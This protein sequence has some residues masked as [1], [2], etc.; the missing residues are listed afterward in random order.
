MTDNV[1][2]I[3]DAQDNRIKELP[4]GNNLDLTGSGIVNAASL[5]VSGSLTVNSITINS[6]SL[7]TVAFS[8]NYEDLDNT[9]TGFTGDYNDLTNKPT[10]PGI[11]K[12]LSDVSGDDPVGGDA[13][14]YDALEG[15]YRP[16]SIINQTDLDA[17][18][19]GAL[20]NVIIVGNVT[21]RFLKFSA[22]AWRPSKVQYAEVQN[23]PTNVS[24]F[25]NDAGYITSADIQEI[26]GDFE[27]SVFADDST[28]LVDGVAGK[29]VGNVDTSLIENT[30]GNLNINA[31]NYVVIDSTDNG[32]IEIGRASGVGDVIIGNSANGTDLLIDTSVSVSGNIVPDEADTYDLGS[33]DKPFRSLYLS[34]NT[35]IVGGYSLGIDNGNLKLTPPGENPGAE[36][37]EVDEVVS[38]ALVV[39]DNLFLDNNADMVL[40]SHVRFE[41][42]QQFG[43][44]VSTLGTTL[45]NS[46]IGFTEFGS[47]VISTS[48]APA[49]SIGQPGTPV[50]A[51][52]FDSDYI[53]Y[54]IAPHDGV[55]NIWKRVAWSGDTW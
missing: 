54:C 40:G 1:P 32:Q 28:L 9:P 36:G 7:S 24:F 6:Q 5:D 33:S 35:L 55:T 37:F 31:S 11:L 15:L 17:L 4:V 25:A 18:T 22:G 10:I 41:Q 16:Q 48:G 3:F 30:G 20:N 21:D 52:A 51:I 19:L 27:G 39:L 49:T 53:Y 38:N 29:I 14:V 44:E 50:G 13:L 8:N 47:M 42:S 12:N 26:Q 43:T 45:G 34:D 23:K 2:L 46:Y